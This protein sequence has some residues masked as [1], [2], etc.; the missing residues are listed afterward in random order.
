MLTFKFNL[1][2]LFNVPC[3]KFNRNADIE[4][5]DAV[6]FRNAYGVPSSQSATSESADFGRFGFLLGK[7]ANLYLP[8]RRIFSCTS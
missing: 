3:S 5:V 7:S 8:D 1:N 6:L 2:I 4:V